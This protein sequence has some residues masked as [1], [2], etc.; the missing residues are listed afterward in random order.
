MTMPLLTT[1]SQF[2]LQMKTLLETNAGT[3][4][5]ADGGIFYGDQA[6]IP[7]SPAVCVEPNNKSVDLYGAGRM[8]EVKITLYLLVYHSEIRD[9]SSNREDADTLAEAIATLVNSS[10]TFYGSAIHCYVTDVT[11]GY[12]TKSNTTMRATRITWEATTQ[13]RLPNSP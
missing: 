8:T 7:V 3:L 2:G 9:I 5:I 11:S 1:L 10:A 13:E 4:G 6:R 12:S